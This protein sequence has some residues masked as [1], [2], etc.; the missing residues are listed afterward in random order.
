MNVLLWI[1]Q[2]LLAAVFV[3]AGVSKILVYGRKGKVVQAPLVSGWVGM[4][5]EFAAII[6]LVEIVGALAVVVPVD[7]W[8][9]NILLRLAATG[10]AVLTVVVGIYHARR[11]EHVAPSVVVFLLALFVIVGRWPQ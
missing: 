3:F 11:Q 1:A 8:P 4:P 6:A 5:N 10:L 7:L 9:P 2:V